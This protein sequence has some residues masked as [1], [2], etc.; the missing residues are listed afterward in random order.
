[1]SLSPTVAGAAIV[2]ALLLTLAVVTADVHRSTGGQAKRRTCMLASAQF[3]GI[4]AAGN[5][6]A[7]LLVPL[8]APW[9]IQ[10]I[11]FEPLPVWYRPLVYAFIGVV[12]FEGII[13]HLTYSATGKNYT[14]HNQ[15]EKLRGSAVEAAV[16]KEIERED[17][18]QQQRAQDLVD[19][20]S[21]QDLNSVI[22]L[23]LG[24]G[25]VTA[26]EDQASEEN[27][28]AQLLKANA[29]AGRKPIET[30][31]IVKQAKKRQGKWWRLLRED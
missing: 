30:K 19:L 26:L 24:P 22:I 9:W 21:E 27:A 13:S 16:R 5:A 11:F 20:L 4:F 6:V 3:Y 15:I 2:I 31:A 10:T 12:A 25:R 7:T 23:H 14:F 28:N 17:R 29:L 18:L 8:M 1:V